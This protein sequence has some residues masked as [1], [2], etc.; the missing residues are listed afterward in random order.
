ME[1]KRHI[2]IAVR[3]LNHEIGR[4]VRAVISEEFGDSATGV[5]SWIVRYLYD[6]GEEDVFQKDLESQFS[7]RRST[8]TTILQLMEKNG[9]IKKESVSRDARLKK[10]ILT[11]AAIEMQDRIRSGI[12]TLEA[13]MREG[14]SD[15]D[16]DTF[17]SVAEKIKENLN[18]SEQ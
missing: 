18:R 11:P 3:C 6:H 7:V 8:M 10:L 12:D 2:G 16:L 1:E 15:K 17:F 5:Q 4:A 13:K 9:L 14:I